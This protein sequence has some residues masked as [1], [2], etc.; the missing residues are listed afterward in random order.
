MKFTAVKWVDKVAVIVQVQ[1]LEFNITG[2]NEFKLLTMPTVQIG[3]SV[4]DKPFHFK[5]Q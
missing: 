5:Y 4:Y 2:D 1:L 3:D